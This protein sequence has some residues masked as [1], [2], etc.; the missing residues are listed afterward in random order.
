MPN[1]FIQ[2]STALAAVFQGAYLVQ[3]LHKVC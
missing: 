1:D 3:Q 2:Q